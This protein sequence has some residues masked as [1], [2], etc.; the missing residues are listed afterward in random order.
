MLLP[1]NPAATVITEG[2][3]ML[4]LEVQLSVDAYRGLVRMC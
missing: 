4:L 3:V 2:C 1:Y